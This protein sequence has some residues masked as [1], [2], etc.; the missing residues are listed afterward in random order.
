M[1]KGR[2]SIG[3]GIGLAV[4]TAGWG[5]TSAGA[6]GGGGPVAQSILGSGSD[7]TQFM[8]TDLDKL[9]LFSTGCQNLPPKDASGNPT[10]LDFSCQSPDPTIASLAGTST[11]GS[12]TVTMADTTGV[13]KGQVVTGPGVPAAATYVGTLAANTSIGLSSSPSA[14]LPVKAGAGA[15]AGTFNFSSV[16]PTE[17]YA[18]DQVHEAYFYGSS[19]GIYQL[20]HKGTSIGGTPV[21]PIDFARS[22]RGSKTSDCAGLNFVAYARD[23]ISWEAV[24]DGTANSGVFNMNNPDGAC[25]GHPG[26]CLT[27]S[28]LTA[29]FTKTGSPPACQI[30]NWSQLGGQNLPI[31]V[32]TAQPGSGTRSTWDGFIHGD[33]SQ[34]AKALIPENSNAGIAPADLKT[35]IFPFS[36]G[37]WS[38]QVHG[39]GSEL[40]GAVDNI[41]ATAATISNG[42][43][44]FG[45]FLYNVYC[46]ASCPAAAGASSA[47]TVNYV[48]EEGWI[49]KAPSSH[50]VDPTRHVNY[51]NEI[52]TAI[53]AN[54][55]INVPFGVIGSGDTHKDYCRLFKT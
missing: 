21:A 45:R 52:A 36:F 24:N 35:A 17:N 42:T 47:A 37:V 51:R 19:F 8:M 54:G 20:C 9:Y 53:N 29:I 16:V 46:T 50:A 31:Q 23:G 40:L 11:S 38:T 34:C 1:R 48:G 22:S 2:I 32:Y 33:S 15:G 44:P 25:A 28:D 30:T 43:F 26:P 6:T 4:A 5:A 3:I 41:A 7:T 12:A 10:Y 13:V 39:A 18:H 49:C 14:N 27:I 55:F